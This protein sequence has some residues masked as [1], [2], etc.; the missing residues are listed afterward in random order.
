MLDAVTSALY[1]LAGDTPNTWRSTTC[2][3]EDGETSLPEADSIVKLREWM[4]DGGA[5]FEKVGVSA[6]LNPMFLDEAEEKPALLRGLVSLEPIEAGEVL[7]KVPPALT[8]SRHNGE[9][10]KKQRGGQKLK[11]WL[12]ELA[13]GRGEMAG[14]ASRVLVQDARL[15][16]IFLLHEMAVPNSRWKPYFDTFPSRDSFFSSQPRSE[17]EDAT[18]FLTHGDRETAGIVSDSIQEAYK[19]TLGPLFAHDR[20]RFPEKTFNEGGHRYV[21]HLLLTRGIPV[22]IGARTSPLLIPLGDLANHDASL[23]AQEG[24]SVTLEVDAEGQLAVQFKATSSQGACRQLYL[25]YGMHRSNA[26]LL[27]HHGFASSSHVRETVRLQPALPKV[28]PTP[29]Q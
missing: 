5:D 19:S 13:R 20:E 11:P 7:F 6:F 26:W 1:R 17:R 29:P 3:S 4:A 14:I 27:G 2:S 21:A 25:S 24:M 22:T 10:L 28:T 9:D 16:E 15:V 23:E 12:F 18:K 8:I